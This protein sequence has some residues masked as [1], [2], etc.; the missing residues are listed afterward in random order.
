MGRDKALL[1][2]PPN[3]S[4]GLTLL[5]GQIE[6]LNPFA[7]ALIIV[8]GKNL[9]TLAPIAAAHGAWI[10]QNSEPE[11]G[12][13]SS[14]QI[15]LRSLVDRGFDAA[16]I[17]L[18]DAPPLSFRT[19]SQLQTAFDQA[20]EHGKWGVAPEQ[21]G[22]R[23]HPLFAS[24][25]LIDAFLGAPVTSNARAIKNEHARLLVS[26]LVPDALLNRD[27]NTPEQYAALASQEEFRE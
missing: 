4:K 3:N 7:E 24:R 16:I 9:E 8:S 19:L 23:G 14:L 21:N 22:K 25:K 12:Q 2:W 5:S 6:A 17:T 18:V 1:P 20:I 10:V 11:R 13:F 26:V 15:G 27:L